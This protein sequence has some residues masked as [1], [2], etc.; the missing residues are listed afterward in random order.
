MVVKEMISDYKRVALD[1]RVLMYAF[2]QHSQFGAAA[3]E[4]LDC[5][6]DHVVEAV[7][8]ATTLTDILVKPIR[9]GKENVEKQFKLFF[10]HFP[11]L[12]ILPIDED[13]A[14]RAAHIKAK[15]AISTPDAL[16]VASAVLSEANVL[17]TYDERLESIT[18]IPTIPLSHFSGII[19]IE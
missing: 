3:K 2:N 9:D 13:M 15:Y 16:F 7:T 18:E 14:I 5:I 4:I 12:T 8:P 10:K 6:E 19:S 11:N 1:S 17:I